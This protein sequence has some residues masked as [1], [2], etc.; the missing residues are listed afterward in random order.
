MNFL[1]KA[2][3]YL[4]KD[5]VGRGYLTIVGSTLVATV[6]HD[7][8][9]WYLI[10]YSIFGCTVYGI[11]LFVSKCVQNK[12]Y[13]TLTRARI[14]LTI[15]KVMGWCSD[16]KDTLLRREID[17]EDEDFGPISNWLF[18]RTENALEKSRRLRIASL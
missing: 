2:G 8:P 4:F 12:G 10:G 15:L 1:S 18:T 11:F 14:L 7:A 16:R 6:M 5:Q 9:L 17:N 3:Q 13:F